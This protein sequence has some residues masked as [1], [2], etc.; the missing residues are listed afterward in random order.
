MP[1][2]R[3]GFIVSRRVS[4]KAVERNRVRRRVR[5]VARRNPVSTGWDVLF[6]ARRDAVEADFKSIEQAVLDLERRAGLHEQP[7]P[8]A[9]AQSSGGGVN[10]GV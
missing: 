7:S 2:T 6:I 4:V 5:E 3:F 1:Y 9:G 10:G 8:Q